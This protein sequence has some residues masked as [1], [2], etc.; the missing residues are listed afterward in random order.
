LGVYWVGLVF[1]AA[2]DGETLT[3]IAA[4]ILLGCVEAGFFPSAIFYLTLFYNRE[5]ISKRISIFYMM[6]FVANAVSGLIAYSVFQWKNVHL[7]GEK[8]EYSP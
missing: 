7:Y 3:I 6:G 4:R 8:A 2:A 1:T 5:E